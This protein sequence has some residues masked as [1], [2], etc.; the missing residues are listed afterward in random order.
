[1]TIIFVEI[2]HLKRD[3]FTFC[4]SDKAAVKVDS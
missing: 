3:F 1:M 4:L 2:K